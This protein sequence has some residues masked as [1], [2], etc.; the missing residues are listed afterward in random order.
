MPDNNDPNSAKR[1]APEA[2]AVGADNP[3]A[4]NPNA[5]MEVIVDPAD[6][7]YLEN[8]RQL[9]ANEAREGQEKAARA[10]Q[11]GSVVPAV[12]MTAQ[13]TVTPPDQAAPAAGGTPGTVP[14]VGNTTV[15]ES[16]DTTRTA[17][18]S[19]TRRTR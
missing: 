10:A 16:V 9:A 4:A 5:P 2:P 17:P 8:R 3:T 12:V 15:S 11:Q 6:P 7:R 18:E 1:N 14:A 19:G 13:G